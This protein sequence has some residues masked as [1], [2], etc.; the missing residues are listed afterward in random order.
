MRHLAIIMDGNRRWARRHQR[1]ILSGHQQGSEALRRTALYANELG[2]KVLTV[3]AFSTENWK[4]PLIEVNG[5]MGLFVTEMT[6]L[7]PE[8]HA[9]GIR[10]RFFGGLS[11]LSPDIR[12]KQR[13]ST[14]LTRN[15]PGMVL[16]VAMNYGARQE[17]LQACAALIEE[18]QAS[19]RA[20]SD[21]KEEDLM[22]RLY[23]P[24]SPD[25]DAVLRTGGEHRL[26][27][28]LLWQ[29]AYSEV[30]ISDVLWPDFSPAELDRVI[31]EFAQRQRRFGR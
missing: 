28:F 9:N 19:G 14:E 2:L 22:K 15:N 17:I 1:Q 10:L 29:A 25:P 18:Y 5:L 7:L 21:L 20:P 23:L 13:E 26:S 8:L 27:N 6:R 31:Y 11:Q 12:E 24:D 30:F 3:Y 4:R 16:Q